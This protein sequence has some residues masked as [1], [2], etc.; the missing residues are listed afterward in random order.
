MSFCVLIH[1]K[2]NNQLKS[3]LKL[4]ESLRKGVLVVALTIEFQLQL[5]HFILYSVPFSIKPSLF[6]LFY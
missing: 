6:D 3:F 5:C 2:L 4:E 1:L